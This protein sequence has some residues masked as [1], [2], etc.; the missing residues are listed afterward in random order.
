V[1]EPQ[2]CGFD[3]GSATACQLCPRD[4][5]VR[6]TSTQARTELTRSGTGLPV[7]FGRKP[8]ETVHIRISNKN[9]QFKRFPPVYRPARPVP[10]RLTKKKP[11]SGEF[12]VF[13]NLNEKLK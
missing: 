10:G 13:S 11:I 9:T 8:V 7:R 2:K 3:R 4:I 12:D 1:L 5:F 6:L